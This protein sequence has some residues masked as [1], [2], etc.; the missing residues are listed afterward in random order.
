MKH[1]LKMLMRSA[2]ARL[3]YHSGLH[4]LVDRVMPRRLLILAGHCVDSPAHNSH[5]PVEMKIDGE[6]LERLLRWLGA[7]YELCTVARGWEEVQRG[8]G[9][10][11]V[12]LTMDDGYRDNVD[13]LLPILERVDAPA[14]VYLESRPLDEGR[15]SWI[16]KWF[17]LVDRLGVDELGRRLEK[18]CTDSAL[19]AELRGVREAGGDVAYQL[20][21]RMKYEIEPQ[22]R[23]A[24]IDAVY[25]EEGG[26]EVELCARVYMDWE[27]AR[28]LALG[29]VEL[30]G[31][32]VNHEVLARLDDGRVLEEIEEGRAS[33][34][35]A[36]ESAPVSFAYPFGRRWDHDSRSKEGARSSGF[37]TAVT[38]HAGTNSP[39]SDPLLLKRWM[40]DDSTPMHLLVCEACGGFDLLRRFG[41]DLSE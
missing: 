22:V 32:T 19:A 12:A 9:R 27:G 23:D 16:H 7:R 14:T 10:S 24:T 2:W 25:R 15:V 21:R 3:L 28:R 11:L 37:V 36:L 34:E 5:L 6:R 17:W 30:G 40:V 26:D 29:G 1:R 33:L 20:K 18:A 13:A 4:R 8:G 38:T 31:H 35:R 39:E 41:L